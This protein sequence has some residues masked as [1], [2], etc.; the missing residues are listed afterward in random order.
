M[1]SEISSHGSS[2]AHGGGLPSSNR[3]FRLP[4]ASAPAY[5][6]TSPP[7]TSLESP[8]VS[9]APCPREQILSSFP[10]AALLADDVQ[11]RQRCMNR[12]LESALG[13][14]GKQSGQ[15]SVFR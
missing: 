2:N 9:P 12:G 13:R 11:R 10:S 14:A 5:S 8:L 3:S 7:R 15:S 4:P 6:R 1:S